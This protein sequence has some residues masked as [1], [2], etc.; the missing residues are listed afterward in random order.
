M[1]YKELGKI[2]V[3]GGGSWA[4]ALSRLMLNNCSEI[5][6]YMRRP[7][8]IEA[9]KTT[10]RNPVYVSDI[11]FDTSR[12]HF[13]SDINEACRLADTL[14]MVMPSPYFKG[15]ADKIT[16]DISSKTIIT[17]VKGIIPDEDMTVTKYL[18]HRFG[19][20][21]EKMLAVSGPSHAEEIALGR[22]SYLTVAA[23]DQSL[24]RAF[25]SMLRCS[26]VSAVTTDDVE[27]VE[28]AA[29]LKNIYAIAAG[30]AAGMRAGDNFVAVLVSNAIREME[31]FLTA[32]VPAERRITDSVYLGDLLVTSYSRFSRNHNLGVMI[33][34]GYT[35]KAARME[36]E[37]TAEGYFGSACIQHICERHGLKLP[38]VQTVFDIL[39]Q[40]RPAE[41]AIKAMSMQFN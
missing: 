22:R 21:P 17:A 31:T 27:G 39:Y 33:G 20:S 3:M 7:D 29:V 8:R 4:T 41:K 1:A 30:I 34:R 15:H 13:T 9:F 35:V 14:L 38:I 40:G 5:I 2:A 23:N 36:M 16:A 11:V 24:A 25:A 6:W 32:V 37:Q 10:G 28:Y 18:E 26:Y 12:I 19:V